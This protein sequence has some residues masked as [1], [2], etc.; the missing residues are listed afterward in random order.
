M[1]NNK[2]R[3][4]YQILAVSIFLF[5]LNAQAQV[6]R[7]LDD[8]VCARGEICIQG[9]C[10]PGCR[11]T[12]DCAPGKFCINN[13][14]TSRVCEP[15]TT[16]SCYD[17]AERT[18]TNGE[19]RVG[20]Q[21]CLAGG[22]SFS[23]CYDQVLPRFEVC[24]G[25]DNDCDG[26]VDEGLQCQCIPGSQRRCYTGPSGTLDV[27]V[28]RAGIQSCGQDH[29]WGA[30]VGQQRPSRDYCDGKDND[31]DGKVDEDC[32]CKAGAIRACYSFD[33]KTAGVGECR[34]GSQVCQINNTWTK[35]CFEEQG[36]VKEVCDGKDNNCDG[37]VDEHCLVPRNQP[38]G[39]PVPLDGQ[40]QP[41]LIPLK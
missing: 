26:Q 12:S 27:G 13:E 38:L 3:C 37:V 34:R 15:G 22:K 7:C 8:R 33:P 5:G 35:N 25:L 16:R 29:R 21:Y 17:G 4:L 36:P 9:G 40:S 32:Q 20:V 14:C 31:C 24:D 2:L 10:V 28:C 1:S 23:K 39:K 30:C 18:K 41:R 11:K 19:C 6:K